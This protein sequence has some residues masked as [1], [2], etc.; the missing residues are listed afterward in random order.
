MLLKSRE[1]GGWGFTC[2][3]ADF[4]LSRL[5]DRE[6]T[7]LLT[8]TCGTIGYMPPELMEAG[9]LTTAADV[10]SMGMLM[11]EM[12]TCQFAFSSESAAQVFYRVVHLVSHGRPRRVADCKEALPTPCTLRGDAAAGWMAACCCRC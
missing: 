3:L 9:R 11:W 10:Y 6:Q 7:Q 2:K 12:L 4:G 5:L 1:D 8:R